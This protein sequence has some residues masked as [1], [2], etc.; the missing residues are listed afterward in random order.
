MKIRDSGMPEVELWE[1]FFD[2]ASILSKLQ[3]TPKIEDVVELGCGYGTF[4]IPAARIVSGKVYALDIEQEMLNI[5]NSYA[6]E[7]KLSNVKCLLK[8]F[9]SNGSGL[10][11]NSVDYAMVFNILHTEQPVELLKEAYRILK[12]NGTLGIIHWNYDSTTP[13]GPSMNIR[14]KPE[15]CSEWAEQAGFTLTSDDIVDLPPYHYGIVLI[16]PGI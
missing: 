3:L 12:R 14:P 2:Q 8:D 11:N 13:R 5:T 10:H 16:K 6:Q 15:Q 7:E 1:S 9:I 4:T